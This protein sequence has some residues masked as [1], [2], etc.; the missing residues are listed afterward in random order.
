MSV[1]GKGDL[2]RLR[3]GAGSQ[4]GSGFAD[5]EGSG[6]EDEEDLVQVEEN[7]KTD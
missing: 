7:A 4:V 5:P 1:G 2:D 3:D 6:E